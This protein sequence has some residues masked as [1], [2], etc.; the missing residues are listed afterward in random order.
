MEE[1]N[2]LATAE[3]ANKVPESQRVGTVPL[4]SG[5]QTSDGNTAMIDRQLEQLDFNYDHDNGKGDPKLY[6]DVNIG[7]QGGMERI[8]VYEGDS[9]DSLALEFC[10]KNDLNHEMQEKLVLLLEQQIAGVLPKIVEGGED[11]QEDE[12]QTS[13]ENIGENKEQSLE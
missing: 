5:R 9:A 3:R 2:Q 6:V 7:K 11:D 1:P 13:G 4:S 12:E 8:V 10:R